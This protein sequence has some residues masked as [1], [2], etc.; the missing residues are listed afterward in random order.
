MNENDFP[1]RF[2]LEVFSLSPHKAPAM[3]STVQNEYSANKVCC[4]PTKINCRQIHLH[5][6][7]PLSPDN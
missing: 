6:R 7:V 2:S 5:N 4:F 1:T 3:K